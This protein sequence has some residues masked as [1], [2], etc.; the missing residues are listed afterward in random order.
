MLRRKCD[1]K[2]QSLQMEFN[3][4]Y[5]DENTGLQFEVEAT[6]ERSEFDREY[7]SPFSPVYDVHVWQIKEILSGLDWTG[8]KVGRDLMND[9]KYAAFDYYL[10]SVSGQ[11]V[12]E[13]A[14]AFV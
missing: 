7:E 12:E 6:V 9:V 1:A 4:L 8:K 14:V 2:K 3:F 10:Q 11:R 13:A 5:T